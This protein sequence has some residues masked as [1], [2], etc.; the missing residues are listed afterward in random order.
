MYSWIDFSVFIIVHISWVAVIFF[1]VRFSKSYLY[2]IL[3]QWLTLRNDLFDSLKDQAHIYFI[4]FYLKYFFWIKE[5]NHNNRK[6]PFRLTLSIR[7]GKIFLKGCYR[8]H[9]N[10]NYTK[11]R[12]RFYRILCLYAIFF[13]M[14]LAP[15]QFLSVIVRPTTSHTQR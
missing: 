5:W 10:E 1:I 14:N 12:Y 2:R 4:Y 13:N 9:I 3:F 7:L 6:L 8:L 15:G 11:K